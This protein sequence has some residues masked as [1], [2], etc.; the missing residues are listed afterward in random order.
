MTD[1]LAVSGMGNYGYGFYDPYFME[2]YKSYNANMAQA[3]QAMKAAQSTQTG[4]QTPSVPVVTTQPEEKKKSG[5]GLVLGGLATVG[6]AALL[7]KAHKKGGE[8]GIKEGFRQM[9]KGLTG[10]EAASASTKATEKAKKEVV[11]RFTV[12]KNSSGNWV[13]QVPDRRQ[14]I[15][16]RDVAALD[17]LGISRDIPKLTDDGIRVNEL[18]F[19]HDGNNFVFRNGKI[20]KYEKGGVNNIDKWNNP[21]E[22]ADIDY[23]KTIEEIIAKLK[24]GE[25][26]TANLQEIK[27]WDYNDGVARR[28]IQSGTSRPKLVS[29]TTNRFGLDSSVVN[30]AR[31][32]NSVIDKALKAIAEGKTPDGLS[33]VRGKYT[34]GGKDFEIVNG[35]LAGMYEGGKLYKLDSDLFLDWKHRNET[36]YEAMLKNIKEGKNIRDIVWQAA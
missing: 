13:A 17:K 21:V 4:T 30:A 20:L 8:K 6:A 32:R 26:T 2:A 35:E 1:S 3:A 33:A 14:A 36:V 31:E 24:K 16:A 18:R 15:D 9:W 5:A 29:V 28:F 10:S 34:V 19:E 25:T 11:T 7:Y 22:Q 27:F 12:R 23:K